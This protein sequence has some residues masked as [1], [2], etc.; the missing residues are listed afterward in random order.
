MVSVVT[1]HCHELDKFVSCSKLCPGVPLAAIFDPP[2]PSNDVVP[3]TRGPSKV[4]YSAAETPYGG[5]TDFA[6][7]VKPTGSRAKNWPTP[8]RS[9]NRAVPNTS[10]ANPRRGATRCSFEGLNERHGEITGVTV[11][12]KLEQRLA[13]PPFGSS[14]PLQGSPPF[15]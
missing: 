6:R 15:A 4:L 9:T 7:N 1:F 14:M 12:P 3:G 13:S 11:D 5:L 8:A 2:P 10:H